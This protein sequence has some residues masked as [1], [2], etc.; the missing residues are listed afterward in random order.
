MEAEM[1]RNYILST[2]AE[3][4]PRWT[5]YVDLSGVRYQLYISWNTR[6][7]SWYLSVL[8]TNG[9]LILAGIRL[10][11]GIDLIGKY[12]ASAPELPPGVLLVMDKESDPKTAELTRDNFGT[13]FV[14]SYTDFGA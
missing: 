9:N 6:M 7:E 14:L 1:Q 2:F 4:T 13:R 11:P 8:D 10:V 5:Q 3:K 12:R